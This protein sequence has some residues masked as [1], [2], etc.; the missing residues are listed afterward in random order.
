VDIENIKL[1]VKGKKTDN[2][3]KEYD[4]GNDIFF[5]FWITKQALCTIC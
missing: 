2:E 1:Q 5:S 4:K 3:G